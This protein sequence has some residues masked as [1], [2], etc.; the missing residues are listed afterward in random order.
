MQKFNFKLQKLLD[1]KKTLLDEQVSKISV[2]NKEI[3][4]CQKK[5]DDINERI[6]TLSKVIFEKNKVVTGD[7][8]FIHKR[9]IN[10]LKSLMDN[11]IRQKGL[12]EK[13]LQQVKDKAISLQKEFKIISTLKEKKF[14]EYKQ[15]L[16]Y[17]QQTILDDLVVSRKFLGGA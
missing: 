5:I 6:A 1:Y 15:Q 14:V 8:L 17:Q 2:L 13:N 4:D 12:L 9:Y 3:S 11:L 16:D 10:D 7:F